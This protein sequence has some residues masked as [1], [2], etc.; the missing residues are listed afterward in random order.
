M[1]VLDIAIALQIKQEINQGRR[2]GKPHIRV[3]GIVF[4][5]AVAQIKHGKHKT[6]KHAFKKTWV[7]IVEVTNHR[8]FLIKTL[9]DRICLKKV[10]G[11]NQG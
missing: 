3:T 10:T 5:Q 7:A 4:S 6:K 11:K 1:I 2:N 8:V 9:H